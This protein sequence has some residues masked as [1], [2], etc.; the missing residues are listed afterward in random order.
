M[1]K[2]KAAAAAAEGRPT[3]VF[4]GGIDDEEYEK[5]AA[6]EG[7]KFIKMFEARACL[8]LCQDEVSAHCR[9]SSISLRCKVNRV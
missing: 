7:R 9:S 4:A 2:V 6:T 1:M 3:R 8:S 5:W